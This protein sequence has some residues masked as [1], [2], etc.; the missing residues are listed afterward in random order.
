MSRSQYGNYYEFTATYSNFEDFTAFG[1]PDDASFH[2]VT[3]YDAATKQY[4][5]QFPSNKCVVSTYSED[6]ENCVKVEI[7]SDV[8]GLDQAMVSE[9]AMDALFCAAMMTEVKQS[10]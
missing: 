5:A 3:S 6:G 2:N 10:A 9:I 1:D 8:S 7:Y 4:T